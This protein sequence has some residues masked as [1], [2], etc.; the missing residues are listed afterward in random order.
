MANLQF[1]NYGGIWKR[2]PENLYTDLDDALQAGGEQLEVIL[3]RMH[4]MPDSRKDVL[5]KWAQ[6]IGVVEDGE[7]AAGEVDLSGIDKEYAKID[8]SEFSEDKKERI[9]AYY[10][11]HIDNNLL[12]PAAAPAPQAG[13]RARRTRRARKQKTRRGVRKQ[14]S[15]SSRRHRSRKSRQ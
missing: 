4:E 1:N 5:F 6:L 12:M 15:R 8:H 13:G 7:L 14:K 9:K 11:E 10:R 2:D 3:D